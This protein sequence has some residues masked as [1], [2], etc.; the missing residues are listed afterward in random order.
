MTS[1]NLEWLLEENNPSVRYRA[2]KEL[3]D[4]NREDPL[5]Q[6]TKMEIES[7]KPV[8]I[9]LEKMHPDGYWL[10]RLNNNRGWAGDGVEYGSFATTHFCL[11]YLAE[12]GMDR[13][14]PLIAKAAERYLSLQKSDGDWWNHI[15]CLY[16]YNIRT[17]IMLGYQNDPRIRRT[18]ELMLN[19]CRPDPASG[20][21][22]SCRRR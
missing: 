9:I 5:L 20:R 8:Q 13:S 21:S 3:L 1:D 15:S 18:I 4:T 12:L 19:T 7:S 10:Q 2:L 22:R 16:G 17:F 6:R 11:A 14:N